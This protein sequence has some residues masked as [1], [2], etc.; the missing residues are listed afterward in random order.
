MSSQRIAK[1]VG[2]NAVVV[3]RIIGL[4]Q[5][6]GFVTSQTGS[7]GGA[8]LAVEPEE[9]T[10]RDVYDAVE[11]QS[12]FCM[13]DPHPQCSVA[14]CVKDQVNELVDRAEQKM[15]ADLARTR[16]SQITKP[17]TAQYR[18]TST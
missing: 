16:L 7:H 5:E 4:L 11:E 17:A 12:I 15:L 13:H 14:C 3:R 2:T 8:M 18:Q 6:A 1:S 10:L 9:I